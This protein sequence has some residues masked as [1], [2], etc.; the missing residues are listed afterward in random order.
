[1]LIYDVINCLHLVLILCSLNNTE[2]MALRSLVL[3]EFQDLGKFTDCFVVDF[4][5]IEILLI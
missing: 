1:M 5:R 4:G 2:R 3:T